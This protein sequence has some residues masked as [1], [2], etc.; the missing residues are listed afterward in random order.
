M[1]IVWW[2]RRQVQKKHTLRKSLAQTLG[3]SPGTG[4]SAGAGECCYM[5]EH[6]LSV[7][8]TARLPSCLLA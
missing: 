3:V 5:H 4:V 8:W 2:G 1:S 7:A 6:G